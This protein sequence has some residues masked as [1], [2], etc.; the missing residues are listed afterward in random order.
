MLTVGKLSDVT[1]FTKDITK[2]PDE[3]INTAKVA[4]YHRRGQGGLQAE[5]T[6]SAQSGCRPPMQL[7]VRVRRP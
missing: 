4:Y 2:V 7:T 6:I 5:V 1:V 3:E